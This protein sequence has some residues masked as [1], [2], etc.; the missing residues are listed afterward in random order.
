[1]SGSARQD[2]RTRRDIK[3]A[4]LA[5]LKG[6]PLDEITMSELA[7][8]A[9]IS[10]STLYLHFGNVF[11][12]YDAVV[13]DFSSDVAPIMTHLPCYEYAEDP[14][15]HPFCELVRRRCDYR[16]AVDDERFL[17]TFLERTNILVQHDFFSTLVEAGFREE[18]ALA[19][20]TFQINGC[21]KSVL[22]F[23]D[24]E[25]LWREVRHAI[26]MFICG[27]LEYC[28]SQGPSSQCG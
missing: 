22:S 8:E 17:D 28:V 14:G 13:S 2:G 5:L 1:M 6:K 3:K 23:G 9:R 21:L 12:V 19:V 11:E 15:K 26:D 24:D 10:R 18:V 16:A 25:D 27:G 7:R 4:L 20:A